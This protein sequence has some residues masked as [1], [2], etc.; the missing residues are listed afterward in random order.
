MYTAAMDRTRAARGVLAAGAVAFVAAIAIVSQTP[1]PRAWSLHLPGFLAGP[2]RTVVMALLVSGAA[3][4]LIDFFQRGGASS[5]EPQ[6]PGPQ[7][8]KGASPARG[9]KRR[10]ARERGPS[11]SASDSAMPGRVGWLL[12][13]PWAW[14]LMA[15]ATRTLFLGDG[16]IWLENVRSGHPNPYSE[17]LA[18]ATW[19]LYWKIL[20]GMH[21]PFVQATAAVLPVLSGVVAVALLWGIG[22]E[23]TPRT[24]ARAT[25][26][27]VLATMGMVQLYFGYIESYPM[28]SVGILTYL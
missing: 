11:R 12:L 24:G 13:L 28:V 15:F 1:G 23:I 6:Q 18:A 26:F 3:L 5:A 17:P 10:A 25:A 16:E 14:L 22:G 2:E 20:G 21:V 27:A 19:W 4:L 7:H 8:G 9:S